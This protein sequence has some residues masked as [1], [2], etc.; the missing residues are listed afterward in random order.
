METRSTQ[1]SAGRGLQFGLDVLRRRPIT[2]AQLSLAQA[3]VFG[4]PSLGMIY[5]M[6]IVSAGFADAGNDPV[7]MM[8]V[9][10]Q[11]SVAMMVFNLLIYAG[12][13]WIEAVWLELFI[14]DRVTFLP[15]INRAIWLLPSFIIIFAIFFGG[16]FAILLVFGIAAALAAASGGLEAAIGVGAIGIVVLV[17]ASLVFMP[18]FSALPALA[19]IDKG[20][21]FGSAWRLS[22]QHH[23]ALMLAWSGYGLL[24]LL[25]MAGY[26]AVLVFG[27]GPYGEAIAYQLDNLDNPYAQYEVYADIVADPARMATLAAVFLVGGIVFSVL[28][29]VSRGIGVSLALSRQDQTP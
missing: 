8:Q 13:V 22:G 11:L 9:Q 26:F 28:S 29:L 23:G 1:F 10:S 6:G 17:I 15:P 20:L 19:Y 5:A 27:P 4:L 7:A 3:V 18:R 14:N 2:L 24:Y 16:Y 25:F 21:S 12:M